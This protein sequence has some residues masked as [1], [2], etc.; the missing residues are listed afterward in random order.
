MLENLVSNPILSKLA[1]TLI[2]FLWQGVLIAGALKFM[3]LLISKQKPLLRY[4]LSC[5]AMVVSLA[6][7]IITFLWLYQLYSAENSTLGLSQ[8]L[9]PSINAIDGSEQGA[10]LTLY[11][12]IKAYLP[13]LSMAWLVCVIGLTLKLFVELIQVNR[14]PKSQTIPTSEALQ[15]TFNQLVERLKLKN[16]PKLIISLKVE[17]PMA[18]GWLKPV[19]LMPASMVTG[20]S[21]IQ[22]EMLL[23]HELAHIRRHDYLVNLLQ[24][25]VEILLFFHP[26]VMWI[27]KQMRQEREYCSDDIAVA[28]CGDA[29]AYAHTLADTANICTKH[30]H[31]TIP[32]MAMAASGGD[33]KERVVRLVEH[34]C[35]ANNDAG[36][37]LAGTLLGFSL[38]L[39]L[40]KQLITVPQINLTVGEMNLFNLYGKAS[41]NDTSKV[42]TSASTDLLNTTIAKQLITQQDELESP[43]ELPAPNNLMLPQVNVHAPKLVQMDVNKSSVDRNKTINVFE[44][45]SLESSKPVYTENAAS[46]ELATLKNDVLEN[47]KI[48]TN[49]SFDEFDALLENQSSKIQ[50]NAYADQIADLAQGMELSSTQDKTSSDVNLDAETSLVQKSNDANIQL[51][52]IEQP[53]QIVLPTVIDASHTAIVEVPIKYEAELISASDPKYPSIA[54]RKGIEL[55]VHVEFTIGKDGKIH[56]ITFEDQHKI[57]YFKNSIISAMGK[58]Q[59]LP[60]QLNGQPVESQMSKIFSFNLS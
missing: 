16:Y 46:T 31:A 34:Q 3:L 29:V 28:H 13:Y 38:L 50:T 30:R 47:T 11:S 19:V 58:W 49:A 42:P 18:I 37:W 53:K 55:D 7:P 9:L 2:H 52:A 4:S 8:S 44:Q 21:A 40:S 33:L 39:I 17:V 56:N 15:N 22:L 41:K 43:T 35:T 54:K 45:K 23:M 1:L 5:A 20:L 60:A 57:S 36:K 51:D 24:T 27:S 59:F 48:S 14:L 26:A 6:A 25:L 10:N 12:T 32:T